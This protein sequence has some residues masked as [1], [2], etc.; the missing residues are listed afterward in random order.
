MS[1]NWIKSILD[2]QNIPATVAENAVQA[3][4]ES[5][6]ESK[7]LTED[8]ALTWKIAAN[9]LSRQL[10]FCGPPIR[11]LKEQEIKVRRVL[12]L[13]SYLAYFADSRDGVLNSTEELASGKVLQRCVTDQALGPPGRPVW[14]SVVDD[15]PDYLDADEYLDQ[16]GVTGFESGH[17]LVT[18]DYIVPASSLRT[19]T[20]LDANLQPWFQCKPDGEIPKAWNWQRNC[21]GAVEAIHKP[22]EIM[23]HPVARYL[24]R[25]GN[26]FVRD[27]GRTRGFQLD[28]PKQVHAFLEGVLTQIGAHTRLQR[29]LGGE[30]NLLDLEHREFEIFL[31]DLFTREGFRTTVTQASKDGGIDVI[32]VHHLDSSQGLLIQAKHTR[33]RV[34]IKVLRELIGAREIAAASSPDNAL[35]AYTLVIATTGKVTKSVLDAT[36][37]WPLKYSK[38]DYDDLCAKLAKFRNARMSDIYHTQITRAR[39][40]V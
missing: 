27:I 25:R 10:Y 23:R 18:I 14:V 19:P 24:G 36:D 20:V 11:Q 12:S 9:S 16:C 8:L 5:I 22:T 39:N 17:P 38:M 7:S 31:G 35:G 30:I 15:R 3:I 37:R 1:E 13:H 26:G 6:T 28:T 34:G 29:L 2:D 32:A 4:Q 33:G 40:A 21:W